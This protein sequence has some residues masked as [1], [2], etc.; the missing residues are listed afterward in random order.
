M[1]NTEKQFE[2]DIEQYLL[3]SSGGYTKGDDRAFDK[4]KVVDIETLVNFV[5]ETQTKEWIRFERQC[6]SDSHHKFYRAFEDNVLS[7]GLI[8]VLRHG[9][10]HRGIKFKVCYFKQESELND[11][12]LK[13]YNQN[14]IQEIRQWH[15]STKNNNSVDMMLAINGI[16]VIA[17]ELK[18]QLKGQSVDDAKIQWMYDRDPREPAFLFNHRILAFFAVDLYE[19]W[20][21][22][23]LNGTSTFFL[24]FNQGSNGPGVDGGAGNP[25][26]DDEDYV[27]SYLWK[28][29][30]NKESL[31]DI[32]QK[33]INLE[34]TTEEE[35]HA[36]GTKK[37]IIKRNIIFPRYHQLDV[38]RKMIADI[39]VNGVGRNY[40][41]QH[42]AGSGKSNS[43]AWA[44][45]RLASLFD[46]NN[47]PIFNSVI[48]ITDRRNLDR[49]LQ[50][51]I[52]GFDHVLGSVKA[53]DKNMT[54]QDL[55]DAINDGIRI[56]I[57]TI[58]KFPV[59]YDQVESAV[60]K[61][62]AVIVDEAH[63]SQTGESASKL[64]IALADTTDALKEY[65]EFE[66]KAEDELEDVE[67]KLVREII[68]HGRH[69]N[70]SFFAFTATPKIKTLELFGD[71]YEDGSFHPFHVYSM[72]QAIEEGFILDVLQNYTTYKTY[73]QIAK[74]IPDNPE[75]PTSRALSYVRRYEE[76]HPHNLQQKSAIIIETYRNVTKQAI[77]GKGK[78]IVVTASRLACVRYYRE[79]QRYLESEG[80]DDI[81][82]LVAF[83]GSLRDMDD[84]EEYTEANLN[85]DRL[86]H[87]VS[88]EQT[89]TV[90]RNEG[91]ILVVA[92]KYQTGYDEPLLHTMI[93]DKK[94]KDVKAVQT[95]SRLNRIHPDKTDTF[96][97]DFVNSADDI[98]EAFQPYYQETSLEKEINTDLI[99]ETQ[100]ILKNFKVYIDKDVEDVAKI[101]F[102]YEQKENISAQAQITNKLKPI[103]E[104][105]NNLNQEERYQ[106]RRNIRQFVRWYSYITQIT[107]MF[108]K[109]LHK[110]FIFFSYLEK[111]LPADPITPFNLQD[112]VKLAYYRLEK[113]YKEAIN[114]EI[115]GGAILEPAKKKSIVKKDEKKSRLDEIVDKINE[116]YGG[117]FTDADR[118][119]LETMRNKLKGDNKLRKAA[120]SSAEVDKKVFINNIFSKAFDKVAQEAY[121]E[122][123]D[124]YTQLFE[125][126]SK[127]NLFKSVLAQAMFE[128]FRNSK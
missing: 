41:I 59:I 76:L 47:N 46:N 38:V 84:G 90:F 58:Q 48:V 117:K 62:Y 33:F 55:K 94:L 97:L 78:M 4:N 119:V 126:T 24:P 40:L 14:R 82:V 3:S 57:S 122:S 101:Y 68:A 49:Q 72:R 18:N 29:A 45:Y 93:V 83:S 105:Y 98:K 36:D 86:G 116:Q 92:E 103:Q 95:L 6:N 50:S 112:K 88:E 52:S 1:L 65:A 124:T 123:T 110:E 106:F 80:Y 70:L 37:K 89:T 100:N 85:K 128:D 32:I 67:D 104:N 81:E 25:K 66:G 73:Y 26:R 79:M 22:T 87:P 39:Q 99:Y 114:L 56:I 53:I 17:I 7:K 21:T 91:N 120:L 113:T 60:G 5:K 2:Q 11:L 75:V 43:I 13:H 34:E 23:K 102:G 16:P 121:M 96:I 31:L 74:N 35:Y 107:R 8:H 127:Y 125:D 27:T 61:N 51:T 54:S 19:S 115:T 109:D 77:N 12:E 15:Y 71:E 69:K 118:V 42:S 108:D 111:L 20:V 28:N 30:L 10:K 44:A 63:S 64:K 9:F